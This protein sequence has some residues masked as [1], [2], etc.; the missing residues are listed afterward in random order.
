MD[1]LEPTLGRAWLIQPWLV[2]HEPRPEGGLFVKRKE[3][4]KT[5]EKNKDT[6]GMCQ[7]KTMGASC[8]TS[9]RCR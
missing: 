1:H 9:R 3:N 6:I 7:L 2:G 5:T 8:E 4:R